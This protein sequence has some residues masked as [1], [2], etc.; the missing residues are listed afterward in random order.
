MKE[1][2]SLLEL[3]GVIAIIVLVC[4]FALYKSKIGQY[5]IMPYLIF[6]CFVFGNDVYNYAEIFIIILTLFLPLYLIWIGWKEN[7][8]KEKMK[9]LLERYPKCPICGGKTYAFRIIRKGFP[10]GKEWETFTW[11]IETD[12]M[13]HGIKPDIFLVVCGGNDEH[14]ECQWKIVP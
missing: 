7:T 3:F 9:E 13:K 4:A 5:L 2:L 6:W 8:R 1:Y 11:E 12:D 14:R 10:D